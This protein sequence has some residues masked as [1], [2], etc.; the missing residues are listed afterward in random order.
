[1]E[2][3]LVDPPGK[4]EQQLLEGALEKDQVPDFIRI[5]PALPLTVNLK[6]TPRGPCM[7]R[8]VGIGKVP[9]VRGKLAVGM[10]PPDMQQFNQLMLGKLRIDQG[11]CDCMESQIPGAKPRIFPLIRHGKD[12][13][14]VDML[15]VRVSSV[16]T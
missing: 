14:A 13:P 11:E 3:F 6:D 5:L 8:G 12:S 10:K 1:M 2:I 16:P 15:P 7:N 4:V 9:L